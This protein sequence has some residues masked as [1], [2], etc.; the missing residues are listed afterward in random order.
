MSDGLTMQKLMAM[1]FVRVAAIVNGEHYSAE[2]RIKAANALHMRKFHDMN[3][4]GWMSLTIGEKKSVRK[5]LEFDTTGEG[6]SA[7]S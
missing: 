1:E 2:D 5:A 4:A 6:F 7:I 3:G